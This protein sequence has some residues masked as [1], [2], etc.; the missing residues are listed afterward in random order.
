MIDSKKPLIEPS[1]LIDGLT[2]YRPPRFRA[3]ID[4]R[5]DANEGAPPRAE[6]LGEVAASGPEAICHYPNPTE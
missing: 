3:P 2:P 5:L 1:P 4:L 6:L